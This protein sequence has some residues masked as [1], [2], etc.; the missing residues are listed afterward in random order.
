VSSI[1]AL[2][3]EARQRIAPAEARLL[4]RHVLGRDAAWLAAHD[5]DALAP[6]Q[7]QVY[8]DFVSRRAQ[9]EPIAYL[10]GEREFYGRAFNVT[11]DV[12]IPR[13]ETE[14]L[15]ELGIAK[16]RGIDTPRILELGTGSGC[17]AISLACELPHATV[18]AIDIS[19][20]AL[21]VARTNAA[22][23]GTVIEFRHGDWLSDVGER[24]DL[25]VSNPPYVATGDPHLSSGD[26][27]HEPIDALASGTDG[28][29][30]LRRI[31]FEAPHC[32]R[33]GGWILLEHGYDQS[34]SVQ[35]LLEAAG[36]MSIAAHDD[37]AGI[38]RVASGQAATFA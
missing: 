8:G 33:P 20:S 14:L 7:A 30:A 34:E 38:A 18:T 36:I 13:P 29:D 12:L 22:K 26:L 17:I 2:I 37:L 24:Y 21:V 3:A 9:G 1:A 35:D 16:L 5:S 28:L 19:E 4:M 25:I 27:R 10:T 11:P 15:V 6:E 32:L 23:H 31:V